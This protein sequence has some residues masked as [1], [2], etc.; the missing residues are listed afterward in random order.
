MQQQKKKKQK[1]QP[2]GKKFMKSL[3]FPF[4]LFT[5]RTCQEAFYSQLLKH[6]NKNKNWWN[7]KSTNTILLKTFSAFCYSLN[8][9]LFIFSVF[10]TVFKQVSGFIWNH[11]TKTKTTI[12]KKPTT[13]KNGRHLFWVSRLSRL[14]ARVMCL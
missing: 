10:P 1:I 2:F 9:Y 8:T 6:N 13:N 3:Q 5:G 11:V 7:N 12:T 14:P 4:D